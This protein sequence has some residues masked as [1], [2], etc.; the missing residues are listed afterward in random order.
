M[1]SF[2]KVIAIPA[3]DMETQTD[4]QQQ[5][6]QELLVSSSPPDAPP[7]RKYERT[8]F[9]KTARILKIALKLGSIRGYDDDYRVRREDNT[10]VSNSNIIALLNHLM[11]RGRLLNGLS[12]L[13]PLLIEA[14]VDP[15]LIINE[16]VKAKLY[17]LI[18]LRKR[19]TATDAATDTSGGNNPSG[20]N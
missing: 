6:Q 17:G 20:N 19:Q 1:A 10:Y 2:R 9:D 8:T 5:P 18:N 12:E 14:R 7:K 3:S 11:S 4:D 13:L 16:N 15:E